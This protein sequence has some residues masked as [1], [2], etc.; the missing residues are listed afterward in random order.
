MLTPLK[1][2]MLN[3]ADLVVRA[4]KFRTVAAAFHRNAEL[5]LAGSAYSFA[6]DDEILARAFGAWR[7]VFDELQDQVRTDRRDLL[8]F[9]GG[10]LLKEL[11]QHRPIR[12]RHRGV[13]VLRRF[14]EA[15]TAWPEGY[16]CASYCFSVAA[17]AIE[18]EG[19]AAL[20]PTATA[21]GPSFWPSFRENVQEDA[22]TAIGF[23]DLLCGLT[24]NW[25]L[26]LQR[27]VPVPG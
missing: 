21:E 27:R 22:R 12:I 13:A 20:Q 8:V 10:L 15:M 25:E 9:G 4:M 14:P 7:H 19:L 2:E 5:L 11:F 16:V 6:I 18:Q 24:P 3:Q 23:F 1:P 17:A 26:P